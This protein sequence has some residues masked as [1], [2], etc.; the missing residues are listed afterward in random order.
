MKI[1]KQKQKELILKI[2]ELAIKAGYKKRDYSIYK[3][4]NGKLIFVD[5]II[6]NSE[7]LSYSSYIK[8]YSFDN[9]FWKII[10]MEENINESDSLRVYGAFAAPG[11][12]ISEGKKEL[13]ENV[14]EI[15]NEIFEKVMKEIKDFEDNHD[16]VE[17]IFS[18]NKIMDA[19]ILQCLSYIDSNDLP[20][21]KKL[22]QEQILKGDTGRFEN[23]GK[24]F[25][26][27]LLLY[28]N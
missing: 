11:V 13:S 21:A 12:N 24:G 26:E 20:S 28:E 15:A 1:N 22:A 17:Y 2:K 7:I 23:G 6:I 9:L 4:E 19:N 18:N 5:F 10:D 27:W 16:L 3:V 8:K 25:F 14:E